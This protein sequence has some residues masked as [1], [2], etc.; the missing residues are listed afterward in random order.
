MTTIYK[1]TAIVL[2]LGICAIFLFQ[3]S[4]QV[5]TDNLTDSIINTETE[6]K[7]RHSDKADSD[8]DISTS[9]PIQKSKVSLDDIELVPIS[10]RQITLDDGTVMYL[11]D[12][13]KDVDDDLKKSR[14]LTDETQV[15][16]AQTK[17]F[18][19]AEKQRS[20]QLSK[21]TKAIVSRGNEAMK[22]YESMQEKMKNIDPHVKSLQELLDQYFSDSDINKY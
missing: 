8:S 20:Q 16:L 5:D 21:E 15:F 3:P 1:I 4:K 19:E 17:Q 6:V 12:Y 22:R 13:L 14:E 18:I 7:T 11:L 10:E 9:D 2:F